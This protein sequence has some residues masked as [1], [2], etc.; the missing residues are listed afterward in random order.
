MPIVPVRFLG[1]LPVEPLESRL[2]FPLGHG[3]QRIHF[4]APLLPEVLV[5]LPSRE[6][7]ERV[8][9]ALDTLGG[10]AGELPGEPQTEFAQSVRTR[11]AEGLSEPA[12]VLRAVLASLE[13][14]S[15]E[16]R[17]ALKAAG[18]EPT[19]DAWLMGVVKD[20]LGG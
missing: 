3:R 19:S 15:D 10:V 4:G 14:I 17:A 2:E 18:G 7:R 11:V 5:G 13:P 8:V 9:Q 20:C 6:R 16:G 12:A 1:G